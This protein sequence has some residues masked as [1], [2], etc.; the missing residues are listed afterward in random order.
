MNDGSSWGDAYITL[1]LAIADAVVSGEPIWIRG[2]T[3]RPTTPSGRGATFELT[4]DVRLYGGFDGTEQFTSERDIASNPT[5]LSGDL[6]WNDTGAFGNRGD[7]SYHVVTIGE[8]E[9]RVVLNGLTIRGGNADGTAD[10]DEIG[11]GVLIL[12]STDTSE[13]RVRI[14]EQSRLEDNSADA[15]GGAIAGEYAGAEFRDSVVADNRCRGE[16]GTIIEGGG[17]ANLAYLRATQSR[18]LRNECVGCSG[19][20]VALDL[21]LAVDPS[22]L[23]SVEF[24]GNIAGD[25][26]GGIYHVVELELTN[27]L[28]ARNEAHADAG[29]ASGRGGGLFGKTLATIT[30]CTVAENL[31][32]NDELDLNSFQVGIG[33]GTDGAFEGRQFIRKSVYWGNR[34]DTGSGLH[35]GHAAQ[36]TVHPGGTVALSPLAYSTVENYIGC[37]GSGCPFPLPDYANI[38]D[39]LVLHDPLF[40]DSTIDNYRH[41]RI[42][43][44]DSADDGSVPEDVNDLD[45]DADLT[46]DL[47]FD[48]PRSARLKGGAVDMG[49]YEWCVG[50]LDGDG[51]IDGAD[52]GILL[53]GWGECDPEVPCLGDLD[54]DGMVDGS[55][56]GTQL[57]NWDCGD[58]SESRMSG[59][60]SGSIESLL[61]DLMSEQAFEEFAE[62]IEW[63]ESLDE[64]EM[65]EALAPLL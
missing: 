3:Y 34:V 49:A 61:A 36:V 19:G 1:E 54:G 21:G 5:I 59:P 18:F 16:S 4:A 45:G 65:W 39:D 35:D 31:A 7:N 60:G 30:N 38:G 41:R 46:E 2:G 14:E 50:D 28:L 10:L 43:Q 8:V 63:I 24:I 25:T 53:T 52:L 20:G 33:G 44:T 23:V 42:A 56:I 22:S 58:E 15:A 27:C 13:I 26:G 29:A 12:D 40:A 37:T 55:D 47:P 11:G 51:I 6:A 17:G 32:F 62:L 57:A 64:S 9:S 48:L